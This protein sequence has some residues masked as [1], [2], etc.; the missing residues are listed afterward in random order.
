LRLEGLGKLKKKKSHQD[1]IRDLPA[2]SI[3]PQPTTLQRAPC[4]DVLEKLLLQ[5][6][7][8][9]VGLKE[10][11]G[12]MADISNFILVLNLKFLDCRIG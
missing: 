8:E 4:L 1:S 2:G 11:D 7:E 10:E 5:L 12:E 3:V 6:A 9:S